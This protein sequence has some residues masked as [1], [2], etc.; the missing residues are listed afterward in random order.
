MIFAAK[1]DCL[2]ATEKWHPYFA[3]RPI[4]VA[5]LQKAWLQYI[6]RRGKFIMS[7]LVVACYWKFEY[8][9]KETAPERAALDGGS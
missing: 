1:P 6:E 4:R 2:E 3:W 5:P 7:D 9:L 8:R